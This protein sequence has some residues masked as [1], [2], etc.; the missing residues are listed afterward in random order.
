MVMVATSKAVLLL[1]AVHAGV[2]RRE[3]WSDWPK[4]GSC[5]ALNAGVMFVYTWTNE[6]F[7]LVGH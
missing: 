5:V 7:A 3:Q 4:C 1:R 2:R 6:L